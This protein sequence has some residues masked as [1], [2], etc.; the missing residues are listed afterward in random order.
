MYLNIVK[1]Y[2]DAVIPTN[3]PTPASVFIPTPA[4]AVIPPPLVVVILRQVVTDQL[5]RCWCVARG[6]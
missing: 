2:V 1:V 3:I 4:G 5:T 6:Q